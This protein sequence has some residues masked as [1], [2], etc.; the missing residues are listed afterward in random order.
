MKT[1]KQILVFMITY[2]TLSVLFYNVF[3]GVA[4]AY[5]TEKKENYIKQVEDMNL[6]Y[7][8][9][10]YDTYGIKLSVKNDVTQ[11]DWYEF[12]NEY[13]VSPYLDTE[14]INRTYELISE[15]LP[16]YSDKAFET[17][18]DYWFIT[19]NMFVEKDDE[20]YRL[21]GFNQTIDTDSYI[22]CLNGSTV[23]ISEEKFLITL[24]HEI[25]HTVS[26]KMTE[27]EIAEFESVE[28]SC[29]LV[30]DYACTNV[31]E[32]LSETWAYGFDHDDNAK[33]NYLHEK[34]SYLLN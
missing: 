32:E 22:L 1:K 2:V 3:M 24:H 15:V 23:E 18:P 28:G 6:P 29:S 34:Y 11:E 30:S 7:Y 10:I 8:Q 14:S 31:I 20:L 12:G 4:H 13:N 27:K 9:D 19:A 17:I 16:L 5:A 25:F 21:L 33:A 26:A